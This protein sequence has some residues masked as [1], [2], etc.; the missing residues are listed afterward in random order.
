MELFQFKTRS[1]FL[2]TLYISCVIHCLFVRWTRI[3]YALV[4]KEQKFYV[5]IF[6][7]STYIFLQI[8]LTKISGVEV[9]LS[10][11]AIF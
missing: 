6:S 3:K 9:T 7:I 8:N 11:I 2:D 1:I 5:C 4:G 10:E